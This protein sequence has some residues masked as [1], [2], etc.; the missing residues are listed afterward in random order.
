VIVIPLQF[1]L[2]LGC[3]VQAAGKEYTRRVCAGWWVGQNLV[4]PT[5]W[6]EQ[7]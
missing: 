6:A 3:R 5:N 4:D 1:G 2:A 7:F